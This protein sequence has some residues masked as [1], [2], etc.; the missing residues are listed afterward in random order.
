M[1]KSFYLYMGNGQKKTSKPSSLDKNLNL[2]PK[3]SGKKGLF[4]KEKSVCW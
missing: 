1:L 2:W 3:P 4:R